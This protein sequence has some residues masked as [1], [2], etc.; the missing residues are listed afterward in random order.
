M[1]TPLGKIHRKLNSCRSLESGGNSAVLGEEAGRG[2]SRVGVGEW[3]D[4]NQWLPRRGRTLTPEEVQFLG[5][6]LQP[7]RITKRRG[8]VAALLVEEN[9]F[10]ARVQRPA[11]ARAGVL[12]SFWP[13]RFATPPDH[14]LRCW[15]RVVEAEARGLLTFKR[16]FRLGLGLRHSLHTGRPPARPRAVR[17]GEFLRR[18]WRTGPPLPPDRR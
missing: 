4:R 12:A 1:G 8:P 6:K 13:E 11:I 10:H 17:G 3:S 7:Q 5:R 14:R 2:M 16:E 15:L 9:F 18:G